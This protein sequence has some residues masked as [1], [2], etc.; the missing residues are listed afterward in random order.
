MILNPKEN[1]YEYLDERSRA[2]MLKTIE[3]FEAKGKEK[4]KEDYHAKVWYADF[5]E[6]VKKEKIF[7][8]ITC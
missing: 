1:R 2:I 3:F 4:L 8:K 6:F 5:I 7:S